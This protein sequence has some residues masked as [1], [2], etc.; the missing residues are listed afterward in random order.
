M[1]L[2]K[3]SISG[4]ESSASNKPRRRKKRHNKE[5]GC[6]GSASWF[7]LLTCCNRLPCVL[8]SYL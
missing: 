4:N 1:G 6:F 8:L 3:E 5:V 2:D 7:R